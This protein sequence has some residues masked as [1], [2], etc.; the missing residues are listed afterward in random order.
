MKYEIIGDTSIIIDLHNGYS[1]LAM[2]RWNKEERLYN[3]TLYIKKNDIDRFDLR[4]SNYICCY[5]KEGIF[6]GDEF[7]VN[8]EG[9]YLH[10]DCIFSYDFLVNW[11]GYD[12]NEMGKEGYYDS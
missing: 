2:S 12:F 5:C 7:I 4:K 11:L 6:N 1:I 9:E 10:R 3:T 8:S